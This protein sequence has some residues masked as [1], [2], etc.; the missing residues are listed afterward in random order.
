LRVTG[1]ED[2]LPSGAGD[3]VTA[4]V[5][6]VVLDGD[7]QA[8]AAGDACSALSRQRPRRPAHDGPRTA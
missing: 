6:L 8:A 2:P 3:G 5:D 7:G 1:L 4:D